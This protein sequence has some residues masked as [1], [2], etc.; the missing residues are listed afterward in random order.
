MFAMTFRLPYYY[1]APILGS[2]LGKGARCIKFD[3]ICLLM[4][5]MLLLMIMMIMMIMLCSTLARH[6]RRH[7]NLHM[8]RAYMVR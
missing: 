5:G 3:G 2:D 7:T 1:D 8:L 6:Q 4:L